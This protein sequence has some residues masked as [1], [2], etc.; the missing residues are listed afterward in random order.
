MPT[1]ASLRVPILRT[2]RADLLLN[3]IVAAVAWGRENNLHMSPGGANYLDA[4]RVELFVSQSGGI[5]SPRNG[6][7]WRNLV[8]SVV[9][10]THINFHH[11]ISEYNANAPNM[12]V[13]V[14]EPRAEGIGF[15]DE[16][17]YGVAMF[18]KAESLL[19]QRSFFHG[20][21]DHEP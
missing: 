12:L 15:F 19:V 18:T 21:E 11:L 13:K 6:G 2:A 5:Y 8:V 14:I 9:G 20:D 1:N 3:N 10:I 7:I 17:V 4:N 16:S